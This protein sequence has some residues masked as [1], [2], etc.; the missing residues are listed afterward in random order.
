M[1]QPMRAVLYVIAAVLMALP[2]LFTTGVRFYSMAFIASGYLLFVV[3]TVK[4]EFTNPRTALIL[5]LVSNLSFW[6]SYVLWLV[7][8]KLT[9]LEPE[10]GIDPFAGPLSLWLIALFTFLL[11]EAAVFVAAVAVNRQRVLSAI[12][13]TAVAAQ[14]LITL[15]TIYVQVNGV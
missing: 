11:Y 4:L 9:G 1:T 2:G 10:T 7:R 14:V 6:T 13:L 12:G 8:P 5:L 3:A 15:R